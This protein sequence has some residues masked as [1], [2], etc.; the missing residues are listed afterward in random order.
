MGRIVV[1]VDG[2]DNAAAALDWAI[3]EAA[4]RGE[5]TTVEV[6]LGWYLP[7]NA[8]MAAALEPDSELER[9]H[10]VELD[11]IVAKARANHPDVA[12]EGRLVRGAPARGLLE[13][14]EGADLVV[15]GRRGHGGFVGLLLGSVSQ[16]VVWHAPCPV[17][18]IAA[19]DD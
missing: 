7:L 13:A 14:A 5:G 1:G 19:D 16:Q 12:I 15:V 2:S 3:A 11:D 4:V 8:E 6:V 10:R 18:V 9:A 17:V